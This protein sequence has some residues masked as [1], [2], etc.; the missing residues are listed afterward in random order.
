MGAVIGKF[1]G[2]GGRP[3]DGGGIRVPA[4]SRA[5]GAQGTPQPARNRGPS[6]AE[7]E[8]RAVLKEA[9]AVKGSWSGKPPSL[10]R[11]D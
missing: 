4:S 11:K 8:N 5:F 3:R 10:Y 9:M 7:I 1:F 6:Q 2:I